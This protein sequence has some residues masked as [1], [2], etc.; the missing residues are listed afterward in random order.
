M[1]QCTYFDEY[2]MLLF[3]IF[4][5]MMCT[6]LLHISPLSKEFDQPPTIEEVDNLNLL[7]NTTDNNKSIIECASLQDDEDLVDALLDDEVLLNEEILKLPEPDADIVTPNVTQEAQPPQQEVVVA[8]QYLQQAPSIQDTTTYQ[9]NQ[10]QETLRR[11]SKDQI[12]QFCLVQQQIQ[13][14]KLKLQL[15]ALAN[16]QQQQQIQCQ[17]PAMSSIQLLAIQQQQNAITMAQLRGGTT[18]TRCSSSQAAGCSTSQV[19]DSH[20]TALL[21]VTATPNV[22]PTTSQHQQRSINSKIGNKHFDRKV[23]VPLKPNK[24]KKRIRPTHCPRSDNTSKPDKPRKK[25]QAG[26]RSSFHYINVIGGGTRSRSSSLDTDQVTTTTSTLSSKQAHLPSVSPL[27]EESLPSS[28]PN[29]PNCSL[30]DYLPTILSSRGYTPKALPASELGYRQDPTPLQLA[31]FGYAVCSSIKPNG[32]DRLNALLQAGLSPNPTNR[33]G[34]SPFFMACKR[35]L[36]S[37]VQVFIDNG[38]SVQVA[39]SFGRTPLH[40]AMWANPPCLESARLLLKVDPKLLLVKDIHGK[41]PLDFVVGD[42]FRVQ[43]IEFLDSV[44]DEMWPDISSDGTAA[45]VYHPVARKE[46]DER[47]NDRPVLPVE[48]A[49]KVASGHVMPQEARRELP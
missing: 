26:R 40:H 9:S 3:G 46:G 24:K 8:Q 36:P 44:K 34:D 19:G 10:I 15:L 29:P 41:C 13:Q 6:Y 27:E 39:D 38:A 31:S 22:Y 14:E 7:P 18:G 37:L 2:P 12:Q 4:A 21:G 47:E 33:F 28:S 5:Y 49:E 35:G 45:V 32:V 25:K 30:Q 48:L 23:H 42:E 17:P 20:T 43:W 1:Y 16:Q 11:A